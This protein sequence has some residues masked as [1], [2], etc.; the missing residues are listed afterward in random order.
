MK[1]RELRKLMNCCR[2]GLRDLTE[3]EARALVEA[4][5][6]DPVLRGEWQ[7]MQSWDA[8]IGRVF[9][10]VPVPAGL[11]DRLLAAVATGGGLPG[12]EAVSVPPGSVGAAQLAEKTRSPWRAWPTGLA[13]G[14][15]VTSA[16]V[17]LALWLAAWRDNLTAAQ[18]AEAS[19]AWIEQLDPEA[20]QP[21][22]PPDAEFPLD[23]SVRLTVVSWQQCTAITDWQAVAYR[24]DLPPDHSTAFLFVI[25]TWQGRQLPT[26]PPTVPDSTTGNICIGVWKNNGCLY[27]LIVPGSQ[28]DYRRTLRTQSVA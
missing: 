8:A 28:N 10:D 18:V 3:E 7:A 25:R 1:R 19:G 4:L 15:L 11:A 2:P 12:Q 23:P 6:Q 17:M 26:I 24:A 14:L 13:A 9:H 5:E 22:N 20:W 21:T 16:I 27:V